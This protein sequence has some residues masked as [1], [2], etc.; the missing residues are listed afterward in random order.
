MTP[1]LI[2]EASRP[3]VRERFGA[4]MASAEAIDV[5]VTRIRLA[6]LDLTARELGGVR[7]CR[8]LL[9]ELDASTLLDA[10]ER[11]SALGRL[12]AFAASGRLEVRSSGLGAWAPD[13]CVARGGGGVVSMVG[14]IYFGNPRLLTGPAF[15][16]VAEEVEWAE[17]LSSRFERLWERGHDVLPAIRR[18]LDRADGVDGD[19]SA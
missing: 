13:F 1:S 19:R 4:A 17:L 15:T 8:L 18:V 16:L 9:G 5:A 14:A 12:R 3:T 6:A 10:A 2:D 11:A 7:R